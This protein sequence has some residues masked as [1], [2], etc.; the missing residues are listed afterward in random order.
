MK[1]F[2]CGWSSSQDVSD[3]EVMK[4]DR[5]ETSLSKSPTQSASSPSIKTNTDM[6]QL[7]KGKENKFSPPRSRNISSH[8]TD[9][10]VFIGDVKTLGPVTDTTRNN[11]PSLHSETPIFRCTFFTKQFCT[12]QTSIPEQPCCYLEV[13]CDRKSRQS[14]CDNF[15]NSFSALLEGS[16]YS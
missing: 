4:Q 16:G 11:L 9:S 5:P 3:S 15:L 7:S 13:N 1:L 8:T 10:V 12:N 6:T 14:S 2:C